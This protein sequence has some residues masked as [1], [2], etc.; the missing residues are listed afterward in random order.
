M[1]GVGVATKY[2]FMSVDIMRRFVYIRTN[3]YPNM[4]TCLLFAMLQSCVKAVIL[5]GQT[6]QNQ[7]SKAVFFYFC[8]C[9]MNAVA[10]SVTSWE[11]W[12][13]QN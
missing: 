5:K 4:N 11:N 10:A 1:G 13:I 9:K 8:F 2:V 7:N 3:M 6:K 12:Q